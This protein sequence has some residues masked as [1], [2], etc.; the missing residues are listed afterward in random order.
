MR[1]EEEV[2]E[3]RV[4][5]EGGKGVDDGADEGARGEGG[6]VGQGDAP[7]SGREEEL[8]GGEGGGVSEEGVW[9][10]AE[11]CGDGFDG[12]DVGGC[13]EGGGVRSLI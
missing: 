11:D 12:N 2:L 8:E 10:E 1:F 9:V 3:E 4:D 5:G 6:G 13:G 7:C